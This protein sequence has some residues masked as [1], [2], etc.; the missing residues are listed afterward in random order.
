ML[1]SVK[2]NESQGNR[3]G[4]G[5]V[6]VSRSVCQINVIRGEASGKRELLKRATS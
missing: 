4:N 3:M 5:Y 6:V 1:S 2:V